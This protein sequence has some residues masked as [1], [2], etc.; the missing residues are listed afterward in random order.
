[1]AKKKMYRMRQ[2]KYWT[3]IDKWNEEYHCYLAIAEF[4]SLKDAQAFLKYKEGESGN[5]H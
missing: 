4:L 1:M 2:G 3:M 5:N